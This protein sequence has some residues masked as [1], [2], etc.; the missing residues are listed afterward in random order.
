[1]II[2]IST[3]LINYL[4]NNNTRTC[5]L[6]VGPTTYPSRKT[7][8]ITEHGNDNDGWYGTPS[9]SMTKDI[10]DIYHT[11]GIVEAEVFLYG[12]YKINASD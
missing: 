6:A 3:G 12:Y 8:T 9:P 2:D 11:C 4:T 10:V 1:M 5:N 7:Y